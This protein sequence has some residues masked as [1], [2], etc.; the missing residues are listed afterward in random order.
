MAKIEPPEH[1]IELQR[2]TNTARA[3]ATA[4]PYSAEAWRPWLEAAETVRIAVTEHAKEAGIN[5][6]DLEMA[7]KSAA[8]AAEAAQAE[9]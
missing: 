2:A 1:L 6:V 4:G 9:G 7:V 3:E 5:R 8:R